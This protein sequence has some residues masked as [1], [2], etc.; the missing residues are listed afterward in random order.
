MTFS[1]DKFDVL[2]IGGGPAGSS[3]AIAAARRGARVL[4]LERGRFPR[5][6]VCG[7][8]I[9]PESLDLLRSLLTTPA[10]QRVLADAPAIGRARAFIGSQILEARIVPA[11][12]S[13]A[14][15]TLDELLWRAGG[16]AGARWPSRVVVRGRRG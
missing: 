1:K 11:A 5:H 12:A 2:V 14:R 3:A 13:L 4:L 15:Y 16:E 6:K 7:E 9:S 8:F 10:A